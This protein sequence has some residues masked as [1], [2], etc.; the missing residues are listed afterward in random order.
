MRMSE[1]ERTL[2]LSLIGQ[3]LTGEYLVIRGN[4]VG[5]I[6]GNLCA[7]P[8]GCLKLTPVALGSSAAE[9]V[10]SAAARIVL[11][12]DVAHHVVCHRVHHVAVHVVHHTI[13]VVPHVAPQAIL[14][15]VHHVVVVVVIVEG[16]FGIKD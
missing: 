8:C 13:H 5:A 12:D 14:H 6:L 16:H 15:A 2:N 10:I 1:H 3:I 4:T 11:D 9:H 7:Y